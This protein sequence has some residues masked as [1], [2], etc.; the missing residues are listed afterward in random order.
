MLHSRYKLEK[1]MIS[2]ILQKAIP[3]S[4]KMGASS[5]LKHHMH[6]EKKLM[7]FQTSKH[8]PFNVN[9]LKNQSNH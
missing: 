2:N 9:V 8:I 3:V 6:A 1:R 4:L 7:I 5:H